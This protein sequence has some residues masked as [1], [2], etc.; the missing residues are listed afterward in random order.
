MIPASGS[1]VATAI[2][3]G[4]FFLF[5]AAGMPIVFA[6]SLASLVLLVTVGGDLPLTLVPHQMVAG[7]DSFLLL[8]IPMF[9]LAGELMNA[10]GITS[11]LVHFSACLIGHVRGGL[12]YVTIVASMIMSGFSGSAVAEHRPLAAC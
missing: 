6:M 12:G 5:L 2:L 3:F 11:R 1:D 7:T 4:S 10:G 8:A 9:F